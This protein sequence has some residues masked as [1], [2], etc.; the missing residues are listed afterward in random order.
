MVLTCKMSSLYDVYVQ[1]K[2]SLS[3]CHARGLNGYSTRKDQISI[4]LTHCSR[5]TPKRVTGKQ[6]R[7]RSDAAENGI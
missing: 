6:Y 7:P 1:V 4:Y 3:Q 2:M 5:E